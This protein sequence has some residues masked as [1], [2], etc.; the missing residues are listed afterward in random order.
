MQFIKISLLLFL[1][2]L[3]TQPSVAQYDGSFSDIFFRRAYSAQSAALGR[4]SVAIIDDAFSVHYN[5]SL[6]GFREGYSV[7]YSNSSPF[8]VLSDA[9]FNYYGAAGNIYGK[10]AAGISHLDFSTG[11][12]R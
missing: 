8:Y 10:F 3:F 7:S 12:T 6:L 1:F 2:C 5:S 9:I 11:K 4:S